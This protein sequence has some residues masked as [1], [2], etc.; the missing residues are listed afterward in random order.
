M[1]IDDIDPPR[2]APGAADEILRCLETHGF[3]WDGEV[4]WQSQRAASHAA[5]VRALFDTGLA[6]RCDCSRQQ[7]RA[8][9][10]PGPAGPVYP[11]TCRHKAP[12]EVNPDNSALRVA[13]TPTLIR[14]VD[15]LQGPQHCRLDRDLG[16]FVIR[17][18]DGLMSYVLATT[19]DDHAQGIT[20]V[21]RGTDLL[22]MTFAQLWLQALLGLRRPAYLHVPVV[23]N[24]AGQK[25]SKQTG[26]RPLASDA[27]GANLCQA[28]ACLG[29]DAPAEL[30][31]ESPAEIWRWATRHWEP[32]LAGRETG[33][34][35]KQRI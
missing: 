24:A 34:L 16:A 33:D 15:P 27:P 30:E 7:V 9:A 35:V 31:H 28:L 1:R 4:R 21:V 12:G 18:R 29:Q 17:R 25:L 10:R 3:C 13:V 5:G 2:E 23:R 11:G 20:E 32:R 8:A 14:F 22:T 6:F 26:A 19:L